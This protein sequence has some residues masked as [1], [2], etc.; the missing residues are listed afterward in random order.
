MTT[1]PTKIP[2]S[3]PMA[4]ITSAPTVFVD[5]TYQPMSV[6][7]NYEKNA[8][9]QEFQ[10]GNGKQFNDYEL[11]LL[12]LLYQRYT[13][14][15]SPLPESEVESKIATTFT[16]DKQT[17]LIDSDDGSN[18]DT[19]T[20]YVDYT[21]EFDSYYYNV[22][23]YPRLFH[24]WTTNNLDVVL[25]QTQ[26]LGMKVIQVQAPRRI[27]RITSAPSPVPSTILST[28]TTV[29]SIAHQSVHPTISSMVST[30]HPT[31]SSG[32]SSI[33]ST[34]HPKKTSSPSLI[35]LDEM[36]PFLTSLRPTANSP[37]KLDS[38]TNTIIIA[39]SLMIAVLILTTGIL[40]YYQRRWNLF[41]D[42]NPNPTEENES[43]DLDPKYGNTFD[44]ETGIPHSHRSASC[45]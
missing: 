30:A 40:V 29:P 44:S 28:P 42:S 41:C 10:V 37:N 45:P 25:G 32:P 24:N 34:A 18:P 21:M 27:E 11:N 8:F 20:L 1:V 9:Q 4:S 19:K 3:P 23:D 2:S 36:N 16:V 15:F 7:K 33:P 43:Q 35:P 39:S 5:P 14:E 31:I 38:N 12:K 17:I 13:V 6:E 22:S 26:V